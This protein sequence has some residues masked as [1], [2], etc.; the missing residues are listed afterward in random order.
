MK[1]ISTKTHGFLDYI[2]GLLMVTA[3]WLL[4][5]D[6]GRPE[7]SVFVVLGFFVVLYSL[8]TRYDLGLIKAIPMPWHLALDFVVGLFLAASPWLLHFSHVVSTPHVIIGILE[9]GAALFT[10]TRAQRPEEHA[11]A[12]QA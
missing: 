6:R 10:Q 9:I 5:C 2:M 7:T 12:T 3:P 11:R 8:L 1:F 4:G